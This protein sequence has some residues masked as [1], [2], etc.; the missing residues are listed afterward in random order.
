MTT[1]FV[2]AG[3]SANADIVLDKRDSVMAISEALLQ[4]DNDSKHVE[5]ETE[6]QTF[7]KIH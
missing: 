2:R 3:Y 6:P 5:I 1:V 7:E 4:F